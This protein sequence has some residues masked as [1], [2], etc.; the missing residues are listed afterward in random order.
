MAFFMILF[1]NDV[2]DIYEASLAVPQMND[3][4]IVYLFIYSFIEDQW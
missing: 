1:K 2:Q 3:G 4:C